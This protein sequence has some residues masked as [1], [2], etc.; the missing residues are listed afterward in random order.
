VKRKIMA[1]LLPV[2]AFAAFALAPALAQAAK[3]TLKVGVSTLPVGESVKFTDHEAAISLFPWSVTVCGEELIGEVTENPG[4]TIKITKSHFEWPTGGRCRVPE[5]S[6]WTYEPTIS[7]GHTFKVQKTGNVGEFEFNEVPTHFN[8]YDGSGA[9]VL[10]CG[11]L[12]N[13]EGEWEV[14]ESQVSLVGSYLLTEGS[15]ASCPPEI[16]TEANFSATLLNGETKITI[17]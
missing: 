2:V 6:S 17:N 14:G 3:V 10:E 5:G 13:S 16:G 12:L 15:G 8:Y 4:A 9:L 1:A 7:P 11:T